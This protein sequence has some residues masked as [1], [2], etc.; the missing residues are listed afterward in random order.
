MSTPFRRD[1]R[2]CGVST[3]RTAFGGEHTP[4][5]LGDSPVT[6]DDSAQRLQDVLG[7][8]GHAPEQA[9]VLVLPR[10][11]TVS[12]WSTKAEDIARNAG[13]V[14]LQRLDR[15][16]VYHFE[17]VAPDRRALAD[18]GVLHDAMTQTLTDDWSLLATIF[19]VPRPRKLRRVP[20][21][22]QGEAALHAANRDWGLA[23]DD[24]EIVYLA[25]QYMALERDPTDVELMMF[26][27][28]NS[29]HCRHKIFNA[30]FTIDGDS[31]A[32]GSQTFTLA[33]TY[34]FRTLRL[35]H[36]IYHIANENLYESW[37]KATSG[38]TG[39]D[40]K[41]Y[42]PLYLDVSGLGVQTYD[43]FSYHSN[44]A[45]NTTGLIAIGHSSDDSGT[46]DNTNKITS[47]DL[48]LIKN[49]ETTW[50]KDGT[51]TLLHAEASP[52]ECEISAGEGLLEAM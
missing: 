1:S 42:A 30:E 37:S 35:K 34:T 49:E 38:V 22:D 2:P 41:M 27:Q 5:V 52:G 12:A 43:Q 28:I 10:L 21:A 23:L 16:V 39:P 18:S 32:T 46:S 15:G 31:S 40:R 17:G 47:L 9:G 51:V 20:L 11:G 4:W 8:T 50:A 7:V 24:D 14:G 29:E 13:V 26:G 48:D 25:E 6:Y 19:D 45:N 33:H 3:Q 44:S 36:V